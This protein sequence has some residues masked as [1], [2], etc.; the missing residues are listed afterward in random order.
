MIIS[1]VFVW[2]LLTYMYYVCINVN[3]FC[4]PPLKVVEM[5]KMKGLLYYYYINIL[6]ILTIRVCL[7]RLVEFLPADLADLNT[8]KSAAQ[9]FLS[10]QLPLHLLI[11]NGTLFVIQGVVLCIS[12]Q[13]Q[14]PAE[15][16][17]VL[18]K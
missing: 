8:I 17:V 12:L 11:N 5:Y 14:H 18:C 13:I 10:R 1:N 15:Y 3:A 7:F 16:T 4:I 9:S 6:L 2:Y